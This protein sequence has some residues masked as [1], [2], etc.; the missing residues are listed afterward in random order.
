MRALSDPFHLSMA[1]SSKVKVVRPTRKSKTV[2][3]KLVKK[4]V[5]KEKSARGSSK[6]SKKIEIENEKAA[7]AVI[8]ITRSI[9]AC[10]RCRQKKIKCSHDFPR[11][12]GCIRANVDCVSIDP[13]TGREVPRSY[14]VYLESEV[15]RLKK[16]LG[17][18]DFRRP[19]NPNIT[20]Y[21]LVGVNG[22]NMEGSGAR[23]EKEDEDDGAKVMDQVEISTADS[24]STAPSSFFGASS[25]ITFA[26]L[27]FTA[28]NFKTTNETTDVEDRKCSNS[29]ADA[30]IE[31][32]ENEHK[33]DSTK[34]STGLGQELVQSSIVD[35]SMM[36]GFAQN[37]KA[38]LLP[39]KQQ[40]VTLLSLYFSQ[41]NAQLPIF[42]R[43]M[44]LERYFQPLYGDIPDNLS[45][46]S[47]YTS[48]NKDMLVHI[49]D[50]DT[51][52]HQYTEKLDQA[53]EQKKNFDPL[54][55]SATVEVPQ[56]FHKPLYFMNIVFAVATSVLHQQYPEQI[57]GEFKNS[58]L[59]YIDEVYS[60]VDRLEA[61]QA[62]MC[63]TLYSL[64]RPCV[65]GCW[66]LLGSTLRLAIDLGLH[67]EMNSRKFD[68]FTLDMRR[69]LFWSCYS[70]DRQ[71]CVYLGRPFG[72]PEE[73]YRVP[74]P[75]ELD[76]SLIVPVPES[77]SC[78]YSVQKSGGPSYKRVAIAMFVMRQ[79]QTEIQSVMYDQK[80]LPRRF[81][82]LEEWYRDVSRRLTVWIQNVPRNTQEMNCNF[83]CEFFNL[84]YNH[85]RIML[86][87][88]SPKHYSLSTE[89][90]LTLMEASMET[91]ISY[92]ELYIYKLLNY[93]WVATHN[94][95]MAGTS[96]LY[97][98]FNCDEARK[99][100]P[101]SK[102][103]KVTYYCNMI[104][105]S[106]KPKCDAASHCKNA[107]EIL[108]A[109]VIK[110]KYT[111]NIV[112]SVNLSKIPSGQ[113]IEEMQPGKY[114]PDGIK[115]FVASLPSSIR[116]ADE[117]SRRKSQQNAPVLN[118]RVTDQKW[119]RELQSYADIES[120]SS[121][122]GGALP[123]DSSVFR[124]STNEDDLNKFFDQL[125]DISSPSSSGHSLNN[126]EYQLPVLSYN[127]E[128]PAPGQGINAGISRSTSIV[129]LSNL[130][131]APRTDADKMAQANV[132]EAGKSGHPHLIRDGRKVFRMIHEVPNE[133]IWDQ[134]FTTPY[135][136]PKVK[137]EQVR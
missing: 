122:D 77:S 132:E 130:S 37:S 33:L 83:N 53:I 82:T 31:N 64:M 102:V 28:L 97:T 56:R 30:K 133:S 68:P 62:I 67:W 95:F 48:I 125:Q 18:T 87:G 6:K 47:S 5:A 10:K 22:K 118:T 46:A 63:L 7:S 44:F 108:T 49:D 9:S 100:V 41:S 35:T 110:L 74:F 70:L 12:K 90:Y 106:L 27:M 25:G 121:P 51:W 4:T 81:S 24:G 124:W 104:L 32:K 45:L 135:P 61:L 92:H 120:Q 65:P 1:I 91:I 88:L 112:H 84:N 26:K 78:D 85:A 29:N 105:N 131:A 115:N 76:D 99:S 89:N 75:S 98:L 15:E 38:A 52:Y 60:S 34:I 59:R 79:I 8:R 3:S 11:C 107:F 72:I 20:K 134:F 114:L 36:K 21:D 93:T 123:L 42:H 71:I 80:E 103:Q 55:F 136:G 101:L 13:A 73:S 94:L 128:S 14:I 43:E 19:T 66:Y 58:A 17:E 16:E 113:Q 96:F 39:P 137:N 50:K 129:S 86:N 117:D 127:D 126:D 23:D 111:N 2:R 54:R 69:R 119:N 57:S 109:A 116:E 40:A